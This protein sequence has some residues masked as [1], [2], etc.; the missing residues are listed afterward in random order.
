[1]QQ[2]FQPRVDLVRRKLKIAHAR[3]NILWRKFVEDEQKARK[4]RVIVP[5][6]I[7]PGTEISIGRAFMDITADS[8]NQSFMLGEDEIISR[9]PAVLQGRDDQAGAWM[10]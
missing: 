2:E 5:G 4:C 7:M 1:M 9:F 8:A 6:K 3:R 10:A